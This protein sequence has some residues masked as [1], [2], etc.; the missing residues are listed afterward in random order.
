MLIYNNKAFDE[1]SRNNYIAL[2]SFDGLHLGHLSLVRKVKNLAT[3]NGG[4]SVVF[5]FKNSSG[6]P[7]T[8]FLFKISCSWTKDFF[9]ELACLDFLLSRKS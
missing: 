6:N 4:K 8:P 1:E 7:L 9:R 3:T 5:T 2:G